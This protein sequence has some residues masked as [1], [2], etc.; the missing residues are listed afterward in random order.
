MT[1][2]HDELVAARRRGDAP[3]QAPESSPERVRVTYAHVQDAPLVACSQCSSVVTA[4]RIA[5]HAAWH[6]LIGV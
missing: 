1:R 4:D 5:E 2:F 6:N 3:G